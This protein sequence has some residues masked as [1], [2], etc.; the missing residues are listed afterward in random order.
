MDSLFLASFQ[1]IVSRA[2]FTHTEQ[3]V[4]ALWPA[5][6]AMEECNNCVNVWQVMHKECKFKPQR[7]CLRPHGD[8]GLCGL[9]SACAKLLRKEM[10]TERQGSAHTGRQWSGL[11]ASQLF[12]PPLSYYHHLQYIGRSQF[13]T[14]KYQGDRFLTTTQSDLGR[15]LERFW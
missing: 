6:C 13:S 1:A 10:A 12:W 5:S 15:S 3:W 9:R 14:N 4:S 11:T 2:S 7:T 8:G